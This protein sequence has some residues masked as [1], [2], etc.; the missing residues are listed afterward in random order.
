[1]DL[2]TIVA[3]VK[4]AVYSQISFYFALLEALMIIFSQRGQGL[5]EYAMIIMLVGIIVIVMLALFG[6][7]VGNMFSNVIANF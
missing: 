2:R 7:G 4:V 5:V 3:L 1:M 6:S